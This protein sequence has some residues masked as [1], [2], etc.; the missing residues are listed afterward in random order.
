VT[1]NAESVGSRTTQAVVEAIF[2]VI[3]FDA[4]FAFFFSA[5]GYN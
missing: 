3:V 2:V 1:G 4:F 5:L